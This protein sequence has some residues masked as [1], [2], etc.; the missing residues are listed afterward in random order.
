MRD[1]LCFLISQWKSICILI[2]NIYSITLQVWSSWLP[3]YPILTQPLQWGLQFQQFQWLWLAQR[4]HSLQ[5][6]FVFVEIIFIDHQTLY[7]FVCLS[8]IF[9]ELIIK[10]VKSIL[11][12]F[13]EHSERFQ[14]SL[15]LDSA[16][17]KGVTVSSLKNSILFIHWQIFLDSWL[18][19]PQGTGC[20]NRCLGRNC[21]WEKLGEEERGWCETQHCQWQEPRSWPG[22]ANCQE[23][24]DNKS[25]N[26][27]K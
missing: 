27:G 16:R 13:L 21:H 20:R 10:A 24:G 6:R 12:A 5:Q 15:R 19:C 23:R 2:Y 11:G 3:W 17:A 26:Q 8:E 22:Q 14:R 7:V 1:I 9:V 25:T 4:L 18:Y